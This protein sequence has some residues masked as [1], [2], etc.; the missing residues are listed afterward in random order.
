MITIIFVKY[1]KE[2][3]ILYIDYITAITVWLLLW[4]IFLGFFPEIIE[5]WEGWEK[6]GF[7]I[8]L[9]IFL[10]YLLE[11]FLH[12]HHCKDLDH[13]SSCHSSHKHEHKSS[14]LMFWWTIL[15]NAFHWVILYTAFLVNFNFWVATT[16]AILLHGIP[17]NIANYIMNHNKMIYSV[18]AAFA[19]V[20]W[21]ILIYPFSEFLANN[22]FLV[23]SLISW[24]L[25]YTALTDIFPEF[26]WKWDKIKKFL[27]FLF[28]CFWVILFFLFNEL[29]LH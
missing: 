7:F 26:K 14:I 21:A 5:S 12:W 3:L 20:V 8:L 2:K 22:E 16:F 10:F 29:A 19:W 1:I 28:I 18:A 25:L 17:Q 13:K 24:G 23:L 15:H 11:L 6:I 4:I 9:W 27:Y